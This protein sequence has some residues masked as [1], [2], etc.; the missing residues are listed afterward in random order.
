MI[1]DII[2]EAVKGLEQDFYTNKFHFSYSSISKLLHNPRIF[3]QMYILGHREKRSDKHL[4][5]GSLIHCLLLDKT[6]F[7]SKYTISKLE[8]VPEAKQKTLVE[9]VYYKNKM[10][11]DR[12]LSLGLDDFEDTILK[13]LETI[14]LHQ[15][16]TKDSSRLEKV[17][18]SSNKQYFE[19]LKDKNREGT[20]LIDLDTYN[21][22]QQAVDMIEGDPY[23]TQLLGNREGNI[24]VYNEIPL[25]VEL[26]KYPFGLQGILDNLVID[27]D[28]KIIVINDF[29]TSSKS[30]RDFQESIEYYDYWMQAVIYLTLV[31]IKYYDLLEKD[32]ELRFNFVV[33]DK[34]F[35]TYAFP[36]T[37][38]TRVDWM[39]RLL[40]VLDI[41]D[42]H[43]KN[44][45]YELPYE[46]CTRTAV[47]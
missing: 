6:S 26:S 39:E 19:F 40:K 3:Y 7:H 18:T 44:N 16:L 31:S 41:V 30:L 22:C 14:D 24:E 29:K 10:K 45:I 32:Y 33:I 43:Y 36:V 38:K 1:D 35:N 13:H 17:L 11:I 4:V 8:K 12:D 47:L 15:S 28:K 20:E 37:P 5:E 23:I 2:E 42:Y 25:S 46:F 27:H 9:S 34:Y 21:Y